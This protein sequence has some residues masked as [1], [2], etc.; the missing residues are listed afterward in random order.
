MS[1][2]NFN[3]FSDRFEMVGSA[4]RPQAQLSRTFRLRRAALFALREFD[5]TTCDDLIDLSNRDWA[6]LLKWLDTSGLALYFFDR[7][8]HLGQ[9]EMLSTSALTRFKRNLADNRARTA[10]LVAESVAIQRAFE[11]ARFSYAVLKG[12]SLWPS[13]TPSMELRSQL[14]LDFLLA[15]QNAEEARQIL[16]ARGYRL[17]AVSD[18]S[19]EFKADEDRIGTLKD[20][21]KAGRSRTVELHLECRRS[22]MGEDRN[23]LLGRVQLRRLHGMWT[24]VLCPVDLFLGQGLH[25]YKHLCGEFMR[26]AHLLEFYRH[27]VSRY[28]EQAFWVD[29]RKSAASQAGVSLKLGVVVALTTHAMGD[30]A[31]KALT[32]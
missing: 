6:R 1:A 8:T 10:E 14:D 30:F 13:S 18:R 2:P 20:L 15:E 19:W 21:Y 31:P 12:F 32:F 22:P 3:S 16:E 9:L 28:K 5:L 23:S 29:L 17:K 11:N 26:T 27:V 24:P 25:L 7:L 4:M